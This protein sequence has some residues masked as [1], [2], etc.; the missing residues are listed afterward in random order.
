ME[1]PWIYLEQRFGVLR[2]E[3]EKFELRKISGDYWLCSKG[4][5][6]DLETETEGIRFLRET[7]RGMKP[8]TYGLQILGDSIDKNI[9]DLD[10]EEF[11]KLLKREEMIPRR[12]EEEG[13]VALR[14]E[15]HIVGCGYYKGEKVSSRIPKGRGK[16]LSENI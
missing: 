6:T 13:Y 5:E 4:S 3:L 7:G 9:V 10:K 15:G 16:E 1:K 2:D 8:T 12:I 11:L 14:F